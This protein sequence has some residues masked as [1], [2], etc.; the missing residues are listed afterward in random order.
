MLLDFSL[1]NIFSISRNNVS[2]CSTASE[3]S[4]LC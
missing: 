4:D 3:V 1:G 2:I